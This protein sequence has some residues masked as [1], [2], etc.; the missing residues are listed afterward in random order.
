MPASKPQSIQ[1]QNQSPAT[2]FARRHIGPSPT[3]I[4]TMLQTVRAA[5]VA[6]LIAQTI[7]ATIRQAAPFDFG[8]ALSE[9]EALLRLRE[10]AAQNEVYTSLIGQGYHGT[11]LPPVIQ[12]N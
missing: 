11:L 7:P 8:P 3:E 9:T 2:T 5:S 6:D 1:L 10:L 4:E 12:R